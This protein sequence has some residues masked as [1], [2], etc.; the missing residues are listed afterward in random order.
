MFPSRSKIFVTHALQDCVG[1]AAPALAL[2][3]P[4]ELLADGHDEHD[5]CLRRDLVVPGRLGQP[6]GALAV[7]D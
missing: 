4:L 7:L 6:H 2:F 1:E 3:R 5:G